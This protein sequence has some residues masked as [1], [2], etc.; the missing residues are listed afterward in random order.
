VNT[1]QIASIDK[2]GPTEIYYR[3]L[4]FNK[5]DISATLHVASADKVLHPNLI[6]D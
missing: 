6:Y 5:L 3:K 1:A 4:S 2:T